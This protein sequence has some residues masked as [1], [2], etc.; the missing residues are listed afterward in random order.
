MNL[1]ELAESDLAHTLE[2]ED[3]AGSAYVL[4]DKADGEYAVAGDYGDIGYLI[5]PSTGGAV[6]GRTI[7]ATC[8]MS[9]LASQSALA[10]ERGWKVRIIGLDGKETTFF[11]QRVEPDRTIGLYRLTL[12]LRMKKANGNT[13]IEN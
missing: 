13:N 10:P 11:V 1:R 12:G 4:I 8:R 6:Q 3:G 2:D 7:T 9:T 5:D